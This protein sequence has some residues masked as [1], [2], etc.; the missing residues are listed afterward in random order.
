MRSSRIHECGIK[1]AVLQFCT[2]MYNLFR[3][4]TVLCCKHLVYMLNRILVYV[5]W[6]RRWRV[7][8][9][10]VSYSVFVDDSCDVIDTGN[11]SKIVECIQRG[12]KIVTVVH[13]ESTERACSRDT[14]SCRGVPNEVCKLRLR[15]TCMSLILHIP[16]STGR[17][18]VP[19]IRAFS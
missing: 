9:Q 5:I 16:S 19:L 17:S 7:H 12:K 18:I 1:S 2:M 13:A 6:S 11:C 15:M 4:P 10:D 8:R 14:S 3:K